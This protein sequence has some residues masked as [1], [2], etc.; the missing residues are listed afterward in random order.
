MAAP[1]HVPVRLADKARSGT[2]IPPAKAWKATRP[3]DLVGRQ[4]GGRH[5]G[6]QGPDQG[7]ALLLARRFVDRLEL[8][9]G[10]H[11][12]D[13]VAGCMA[14]ALARASLFGRAPVIHDLDLAFTLWG[15]LGGA[16]PELVAYRT[17]LFSGASHH[18]WDQRR[19]VD[20]VPES[21]LRLTPAQARQKLSD[22]RGLLTV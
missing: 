6:R 9:P 14:V 1:E 17:P 13:A 3:A 15:Y 12:E 20:K 2:P 5:M 4:P 8:A 16:P 10:A 19:I 18:Y 7:Y 21:T 11:K 22:W